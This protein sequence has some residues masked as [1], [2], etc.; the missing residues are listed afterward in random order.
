LRSSAAPGTL[1]ATFKTAAVGPCSA[2]SRLSR[3][4]RLTVSSAMVDGLRRERESTASRRSVVPVGRVGCSAC[5]PYPNPVE[6]ED[7]M[8]VMFRL[9]TYAYPSDPLAGVVV[10]NQPQ[11]SFLAWY[12]H[13]T[14]ELIR[15]SANRLGIPRIV[16]AGWTL[17]TLAS[18][19]GLTS[20]TSTFL[21]DGSGEI[22]A[23]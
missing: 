4:T 22:P 19:D 20:R 3:I 14:S 6:S 12:C 1:R 16:G 8:L 2:R 13:S 7:E 21:R 10:D 23:P 15:S 9:S 17:R 18:S 11:I 5:M